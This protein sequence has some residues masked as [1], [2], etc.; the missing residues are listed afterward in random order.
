MKLRG[1]FEAP[2]PRAYAQDEIKPIGKIDPTLF[3]ETTTW[4][5]EVDND[6]NHAVGFLL[7]LTGIVLLVEEEKEIYNLVGGSRKPEDS[8]PVATLKREA[9]E[10]LG[11]A[12]EIFE[13]EPMGMIRARPGRG[14]ELKSAVFMGRA[15]VPEVSFKVSGL[16]ASEVAEIV[17]KSGGSESVR[18]GLGQMLREKIAPKDVYSEVRW[19]S[20]DG[21]AFA[22]RTG[23]QV[24]LF[25]ALLLNN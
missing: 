1:G 20:L 10:E 2:E 5:R 13:I 23:D 8:D 4:Q 19:V 21:E 11:R 22:R 24:V 16:A 12:A 7:T 25:S 6:W 14:G 18:S 17:F 9:R 15:E 3:R